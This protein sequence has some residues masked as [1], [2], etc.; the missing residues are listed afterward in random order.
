MTEFSTTRASVAYIRT[1]GWRTGG[2]GSS[3]CACRGLAITV[4]PAPDEYFP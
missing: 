1:E 2:A 3:D 4:A